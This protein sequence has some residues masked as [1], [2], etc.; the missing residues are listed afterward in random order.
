VTWQAARLLSE[1]TAPAGFAPSFEKAHQAQLNSWENL[2]KMPENL[3]KPW[4]M[5]EH[6]GKTMENARK[7]GTNLGQTSSFFR[8][9]LF[10]GHILGLLGPWPRWQ[11]KAIRPEQQGIGKVTIADQDL[12]TCVKIR[13]FERF[14]QSLRAGSPRH[15]LSSRLAIQVPQRAAAL[16]QISGGCNNDCTRFLHGESSQ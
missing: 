12:F 2:R 1:G 3:G 13:R 8:S 7:S 5:P 10:D 11:G 14:I 15:R 4:K 9:G 16:F 6:S